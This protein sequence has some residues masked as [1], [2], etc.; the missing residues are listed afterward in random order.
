[1]T[2]NVKFPDLHP[3]RLAIK[4]SK[5]GERSVRSGH[6]WVFSES[7]LKINKDGKAGDLA[8]IFG[9]KSNEVVGIGLFDPTSP[10][11][12]K[13]L[14]AGGPAKIDS[15][16]FQKKIKTAF[17]KRK[18]L[19]ATNTNSYRLL[20]GENDGLPGCIADVYAD[21]LVVKLYSAMWFPY[22]E[23]I[24]TS[25]IEVSGV[26]TAVLRLN[27]KLLNANT[28]GLEE[29]S[30]LYGELQD[31]NVHFVEHGV[32]F[33]ANVLRGHKTGYFLDH[34]HNRK[35]VGAVSK[36]KTVLDVFSYAGG[37]S[38]HA[39]AGGA[40]EVISVDISK[41][42]LEVAKYNSG[43]NS[44]GGAHSTMAGDAFEIL[45]QLISEGKTF[46][47]VVI[48]PPSFAKSAKEVASAKKRY[49]ELA[50]LG[51]C[52]VAKGGILVLAS[53]SSRVLAEEFFEIN[54]K[55][56]SNCGRSFHLREKTYHDT[57][58]PISFPEG[59]YLKTAYYQL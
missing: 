32:N 4:L 25:L 23:M 28:F 24:L 5:S 56:L 48:D 35:R 57:D 33:S 12:I 27:R 18:P 40:S 3:S 13:M 1:M 15:E 26:R 44:F 43:L 22:L 38:V 52:L 59:S 39:L 6:P 9:N 30:V 49:A 45:Q 10:I 8:I 42:A 50:Q 21:V 51:S 41:Q 2:F 20:Y 47:I 16:F 55:V 29:G 14:H 34:R 19:L 36:G 54:H 11:R 31:E 7:V 53:C 46:D 37:F 58:H 17:E